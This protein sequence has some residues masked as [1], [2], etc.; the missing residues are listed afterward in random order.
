MAAMATWEDGPEYAPSERPGRF[1]APAAAPLSRAEPDADPVPAATEVPA[2]QP[3]YG[4]PEAPPL[5]VL[6]LLTE[7]G[8]DP[9]QPYRT[10]R[11]ALTA[12]ADDSPRRAQEAAP[13][14]PFDTAPAT[15]PGFDPRLPMR[16]VL[17]APAPDFPPP[18]GPPV[19]A[20]RGVPPAGF[21]QPGTPQWFGPSSGPPPSLPA[22]G[23]GEVL[24]ALT[25]AVVIF[26]LLGG[27]IRPLSLPF[28]VIAMFCSVRIRYRRRLVR[29]VFLGALGA[30]LTLSL[31]L[32]ALSSSTFGGWWT[33]MSSVLLVTSWVV[34][35]VLGFV[36][37]RALQR[38]ERPDQV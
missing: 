13:G 29:N 37:A 15:E 11:A 26:L 36:Q 10:E 18:Q 2:G 20:D 4:A 25:P 6:G 17:A 8:R 34:L 12:F 24:R 16:E 5:E 28:F 23:F 1:E 7:P 22:P 14:T 9:G 19:P 35:V 32:L 33:D 21:P 31:L 30:G 27:L 3:H 38:G